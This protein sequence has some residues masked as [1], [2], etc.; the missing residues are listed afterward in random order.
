MHSMSESAGLG[1]LAAVVEQLA[2]QNVAALPDGEAAHRVLMLRRLLDRL[3]GQWLRE[4]AAVDG[5]GAAGAEAGSHADSTAGWLR[6][7]L[8]AGHPQAS[9]WVRT[10]RALFRGPLGGTGRALAAGDI[11]PAHAAVLAACTQDL[12]AATAAEAEPVLLVAAGRLD[13]SRLRQVVTHLREV[14]DPD[15]ADQHAQRHHQ[16]RGLWVSPPSTGWSPSMVC[17]RPR[18]ARPC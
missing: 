13:P 7:R 8:R 15:V 5:R 3:E 9:R 16:Q 18:P 17:W 1:P 2:T 12:P 10:A 14:A 4:L 6:G 11:S